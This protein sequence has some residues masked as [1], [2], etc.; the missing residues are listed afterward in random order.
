M[1]LVITILILAII[2][3]VL[4]QIY[5]INLRKF[6]QFAENEEEK[7]NKEGNKYP[8]NIELCKIFLKKLNNYNV[9]IEED[10]NAKTSMYIALTN[11]II[12]AD[13]KS[14]FTR[15]Q[16]IAHECL[17]SVQDRKIQV[18]NFIYSNIYLL[19][20]FI[21]TILAIF[22]KLNTPMLYLAIMIALS[23]I[24]YFVRSYL[25]NDA[26]IKATFL[27]TEYLKEAKISEDTEIK[28]IASSYTKIT[29]TGVKI[30][31]FQLMLETLIK[32]I[33]LAIAFLL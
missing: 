19:Y 27:A 29:D 3:L 20:F 33:I 21:T 1:S 17:H 32:T 9:K 25:E 24:Y 28:K 16:T 13:V 26:M 10:K 14:S 8:S 6:K 7:F 15:I 22:N 11:K 23:Y 18:F 2:L 12:I 4:S 5:G 30:V 31:N